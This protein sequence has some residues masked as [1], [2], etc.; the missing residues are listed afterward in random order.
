MDL[1]CS[2]WGKKRVSSLISSQLGI[3]SASRSTHIHNQL[4]LHLLVQTCTLHRARKSMALWHL[5]SCLS[6]HDHVDLGKEKVKKIIRRWQYHYVT[7]SRIH[8]KGKSTLDSGIAIRLQPASQLWLA[9]IGYV[10]NIGHIRAPWEKGATVTWLGMLAM[11][12]RMWH[13]QGIVD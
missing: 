10:K 6:Q 7:V 4:H 5:S 1:S 13:T 8:L 12:W 9:S 11:A 2:D 3:F